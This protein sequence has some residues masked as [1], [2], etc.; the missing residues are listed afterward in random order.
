M[1]SLVDI[2]GFVEMYEVLQPEP[3]PESK[4]PV[5]LTAPVELTS[6]LGRS[7]RTRG[8]IRSPSV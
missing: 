8:I 2:L 1:L 5:S 4:T 3:P 6:A 7:K